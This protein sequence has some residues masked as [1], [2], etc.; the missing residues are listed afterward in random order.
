MAVAVYLVTEAL[1][2]ARLVLMDALVDVHFALLLVE[3][4][5]KAL[6]QDLVPEHVEPAALDA[7]VAALTAA[8]EAVTAH[9]QALV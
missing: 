8:M 7:E 9:V 1:D 4:D 3:M 6:V 2:L 5:A